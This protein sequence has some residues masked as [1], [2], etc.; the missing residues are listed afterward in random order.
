MV[1][2]QDK[3]GAR[4]DVIALRLQQQGKNLPFGDGEKFDIEPGLIGP[5]KG[6]RVQIRKKSAV[7][8]AMRALSR[9]GSW[10]GRSR[11]VSIT[12]ATHY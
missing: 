7:V 2:R 3:A 11:P 12:L 9:P 1:V 10:T 6:D 8:T 4:E 5:G